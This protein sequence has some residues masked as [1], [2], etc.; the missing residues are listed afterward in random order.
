MAYEDFKG[1]ERRTASD[2]IL[3][4]KA[5]N[6]AKN[7]N[8]DEYERGLGSMVY[9]FL[10][11]KSAGSGVNANVNKSTINNKKLAQELH[12]TIIRKLKKTQFIQDSKKIF[13]CVS[14]IFF[15]NMLGLSLWKIKKL[16]EK[17]L[18]KSNGKPKKLWAG[19]GSE[20]DHSFVKSWLKDNDIEMYSINN[21]G[22]SIVAERFIK[23]L[24]TK[25]CKYMTS[26]SRNVNINKLDDIANEYKKYIP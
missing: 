24:K 3:R 19:K 7:P 14:L 20:F 22:K 13:C 5:F 10:D 15:V 23:T 18:K 25:I 6:I 21:E 1:L 17:I 8:Y 2:R 12:K 11:K 9:T 4:N 16:R 26:I